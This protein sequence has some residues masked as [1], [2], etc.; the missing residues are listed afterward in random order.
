MEV[1]I[2]TELHSY[3]AWHEN[4]VLLMRFIFREWNFLGILP[5]IQ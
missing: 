4:Q 2:F 3:E 5:S 1:V